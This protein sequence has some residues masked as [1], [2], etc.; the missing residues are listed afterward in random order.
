MNSVCSMLHAKLVH[1]KTDI[2]ARI[3]PTREINGLSKKA[4]V[5]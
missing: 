1:V 2:T 5:L 3:W 4:N